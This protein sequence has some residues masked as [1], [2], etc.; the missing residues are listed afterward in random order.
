MYVLVYFVAQ[1]SVS[2]K[3]RKR[4]FLL[5]GMVSSSLL[6]SFS[7]LTAYLLKFAAKVEAV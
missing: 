5:F 4:K 3:I 7:N 1:A 2:V 6:P